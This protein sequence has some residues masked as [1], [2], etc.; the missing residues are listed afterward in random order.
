VARVHEQ[1]KEP[2]LEAGS[3]ADEGKLRRLLWQIL[4]KVEERRGEA[5]WPAGFVS[6][7]AG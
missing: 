7:L 6:R 4:A 2:L 1:A 3:I 5:P